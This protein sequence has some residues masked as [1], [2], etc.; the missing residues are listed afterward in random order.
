MNSAIRF[1]DSI[2]ELFGK[3]ERGSERMRL[4]FWLSGLFI[5]LNALFLY[6]ENFTLL[7][8]PASLLILILAFFKTEIVFFAVVAFTPLSVNIRDIG[9]GFG[10]SLPGEPLIMLL[11]GV[12]ILKLLLEGS[13]DRKIIMH[14]ISI[15]ILLH[16]LWI[17]ITAVSSSMPSVSFKFLLSR[18]WFVGVFYFM[19]TQIFANKEKR[20]PFLLAYIWTLA[21]VILYTTWKHSHYGFDEKIA[22]WI[23]DPFFN[24]HTAYAAAIAMFLPALFWFAIEK[25]SPN[26]QKGLNFFLLALF[27]LGIVLSYTRAAWVS[28]AGAVGVMTLFLLRIKFRTV[29]LVGAT[30]LSLFLVFQT[31]IFLKLERNRQDSSKD[32]SR[33]LQ[34]ISNISTDASNLE[35]INRWH[36]ALRMFKEHPILGF[37]PGTYQFQYAPFQHSSELTII[38][39]NSGTKGTAHSEFLG[40]MAEQGILGVILFAMIIGL[41]LWRAAFVYTNTEGNDK[42]FVLVLILGLVTYFV[43]A[44][45]NNFLDSDKASVPFWGFIA[46]ITALD[47]QI[48]S[49]TLPTKP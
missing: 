45:L 46:L 6:Q 37:G 3:N 36:S 22:H 39:T 44:F 19:A 47:I 15:L 23:M 42:Y 7:L 9:M 16:L 41:V 33:H 4:F 31:Q 5:A 8:V 28:L 32:F 12:F 43:H 11:L 17:G 14:P 34:S 26:W 40:P 18:L 24:D 49:K 1:F 2:H 20:K 27:L 35:R 25:E 21:I 10:I 38:S 30:L 13:F 48:T 29:L